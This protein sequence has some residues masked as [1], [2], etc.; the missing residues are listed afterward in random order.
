VVALS[1]V[2][3][4]TDYP[5]AVSEPNLRE[6]LGERPSYRSLEVARA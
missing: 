3:F 1:R 4:A 5:Q 2:V 6:R